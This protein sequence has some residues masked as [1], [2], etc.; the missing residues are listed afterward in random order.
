M[1]QAGS[2]LLATP[3][4]FG[5][6]ALFSV[7][8]AVFDRDRFGWQAIAT[9]VLLFIALS[10]NRMLVVGVQAFRSKFEREQIPYTPPEMLVSPSRSE[11]E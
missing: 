4:A 10:I 1:L 5:A 3:G 11:G 2:D 8:W 9:I 7:A 6:A